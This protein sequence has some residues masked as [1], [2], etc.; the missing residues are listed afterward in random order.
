MCSKEKTYFMPIN[1]N[2]DIKRYNEHHGKQV[3]KTTGEHLEEIM[4]NIVDLIVACALEG[5]NYVD[6]SIE[7]KV[8]V[9]YKPEEK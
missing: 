5:G 9:K 7:I 8:S 2:E 1:R 3:F 4:D 6:D